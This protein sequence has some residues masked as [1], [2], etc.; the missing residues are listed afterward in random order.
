MPVDLASAQDAAVARSLERTPGRVAACGPATLYSVQCKAP[1]I[2]AKLA[3]L[4]RDMHGYRSASST[5]IQ[6]RGILRARVASP[7]YSV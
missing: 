4:L 2:F 7:S 1:G 3:S 6:R 5:G